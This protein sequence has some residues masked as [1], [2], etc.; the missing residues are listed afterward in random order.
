MRVLGI[1]T[2]VLT[3]LFTL[4]FIGLVVL[5]VTFFDTLNNNSGDIVLVYAVVAL[6]IVHVL[7]LWFNASTIRYHKQAQAGSDALVLDQLEEETSAPKR[8]LTPRKRNLGIVVAILTSLVF[9]G[10]ALGVVIFVLEELEAQREWGSRFEIEALGIFVALLLYVAL[11]L[12][13]IFAT[14]SL[15]SKPQPQ[16]AT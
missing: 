11:K 3:S 10:G 7:E 1:I 15:R 4:L 6:A 14:L 5:A 9:A 13:N 2:L 16:N 12:I 8:S